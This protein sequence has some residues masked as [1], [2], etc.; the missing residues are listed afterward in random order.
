LGLHKIAH[1]PTWDLLQVVITEADV[2]LAAVNDYLTAAN[3]A[4]NHLK[5]SYDIDTIDICCRSEHT[6]YCHVSVGGKTVTQISRVDVSWG[7]YLPGRRDD[8][9]YVR[10]GLLEF[11]KPGTLQVDHFR[12]AQQTVVNNGGAKICRQLKKYC[13]MYSMPRAACYSYDTLVCLVFDGDMNTWAGSG[14]LPGPKTKASM[15]WV[16]RAEIAANL[17]VFLFECLRL[18]LIQ[19]GVR[20]IATAGCS[21]KIR[22]C[23]SRVSSCANSSLCTLKSL[24][25]EGLDSRRI[26]SLS[27]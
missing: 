26:V 23:A 14:G 16:E 22:R 7:Y 9:A 8:R 2:V 27:F 13:Q 20:T 5:R 11:K 6:H 19:K 4:L 12:N 18:S 1:P 15:R 17:V 24:V 21:S 25:H 10:F 3:I